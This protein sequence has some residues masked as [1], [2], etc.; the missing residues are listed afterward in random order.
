LDQFETASESDGVNRILMRRALANEDPANLQVH[1]ETAVLDR[2]R[3]AEGYK[4][5]RT[6]TVGRLTKPGA[7]SIDFGIAP[8]ELAIHAS[9]AALLG[10]PPEDGHHWAAHALMLPGSSKFLQMRLFPSSCFDDGEIRP[11]D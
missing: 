7:W 2:Y 8:D 5:I 3:G 4:L 10:L 1:F 6:D 9:F 11:W